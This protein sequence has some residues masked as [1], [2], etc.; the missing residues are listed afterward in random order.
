MRMIVVI[1]SVPGFVVVVLLVV[2]DDDHVV[3]RGGKKFLNVVPFRSVRMM[4]KPPPTPQERM[5]SADAVLV[6]GV[7]W[8]FSCLL[9]LFAVLACFDADE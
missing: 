4:M 1:V 8:L 7:C 9:W 6:D 5:Y 2:I 3:V